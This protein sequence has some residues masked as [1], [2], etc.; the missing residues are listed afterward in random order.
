MFVPD[1]IRSEERVH[2]PNSGL[3][4]GACPINTEFRTFWVTGVLWGCL[5]RLI[6]TGVD[7]GEYGALSLGQHWFIMNE[8][9]GATHPDS[10]G[11]GLGRSDPSGD[12]TACE[13]LVGCESASA[14]IGVSRGSFVGEELSGLVEK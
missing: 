3:E 1:S 5:V 8:G 14:F 13:A 7:K 9:L 2:R 10:V 11:D 12:E 4:D 6:A